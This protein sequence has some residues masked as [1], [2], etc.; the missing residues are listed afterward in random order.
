MCSLLA[1]VP[2][3]GLHQCLHGRLC[4]VLR[5]VDQFPY[6]LWGVC[7][8]WQRGGAV[9]ERLVEVVVTHCLCLPDPGLRGF[10][11]V[12]T[13]EGSLGPLEQ[14]VEGLPRGA[15]SACGSGGL[16]ESLQASWGVLWVYFWGVRLGHH[17]DPMCPVEEPPLGVRFQD[18]DTAKSRKRKPL[19]GPCTT[20]SRR[21]YSNTYTTSS[22]K[23]TKETASV[24]R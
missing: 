4:T 15:S 22:Y 6:C 2:Q 17:E 9:F 5:E 3:P 8:P 14:R 20:Q 7:G 16:Y 11:C 19:N 13:V 10:R 23:G 12:G 18:M 21:T 1:E 24:Y